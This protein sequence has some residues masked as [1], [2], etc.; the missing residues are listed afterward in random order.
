MPYQPKY[1]NNET[2]ICSLRLIH[3]TCHSCFSGGTET[4]FGGFSTGKGGVRFIG[5]NTIYL[6]I[7]LSI[8]ELPR[9]LHM[10]CSL[11]S[12][13]K[14]AALHP[15]P[16]Q[17]SMSISAPPGSCNCMVLEP[18]VTY[19]LYELWYPMALCFRVK[20]VG[21]PLLRIEACKWLQLCHCQYLDWIRGHMLRQIQ[22]IYC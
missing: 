9:S 14:G 22:A 16:C 7:C 19:F 3:K 18:G 20:R 5:V 13:Y 4:T 17:T 10:S 15:I 6:F 12:Q 2:S 21:F 1:A 8:K 11:N